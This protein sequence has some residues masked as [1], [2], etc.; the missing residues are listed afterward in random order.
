[1]EHL[2][3][4]A[5][6]DRARGLVERGPGGVQLGGR[7]GEHRGDELVVAEPLPADHPLAR[8]T[9]V[10]SSTS[11]DAAPTQRAATITRSKRNQSWVNVIPSPSAPISCEAGTRTSVNDTIG[12]WSAMWWEYA[13][14]RTTSMPGRRQVDDQQHV[15][16]RVRSVGEHGL[17]E[18]VVGEVVRRDVPLGAVDDVRRRPSR[19][20]VVARSLTSLPACSSVIA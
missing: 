6:V 4:L 11:R 10:I 9:S 15:L 12:C 18:A 3:V 2:A 16:A 7:V 17:D 5:G 1:M 14:V 20:A 19:R 13:G 8:R